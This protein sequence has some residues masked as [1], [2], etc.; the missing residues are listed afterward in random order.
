MKQ[1]YTELH[2]HTSDTSRCAGVGAK[3]L[4]A[5]YKQAG[6]STVVLTDHLSPS[7][8]EAYSQGSLSW[9][10]KPQQRQQR[11]QQREQWQPARN[12]N[13]SCEL[14]CRFPA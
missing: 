11:S 14:A 1:F 8:F 7:T 4:V 9:T 5:L 13:T 6:A 2:A 10:E 3:D 12:R